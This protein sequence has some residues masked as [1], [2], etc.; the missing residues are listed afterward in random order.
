MYFDWS[1]GNWGIA[2]FLSQCD[3]LEIPNWIRGACAKLKQLCDPP[4]PGKSP[5][6]DAAAGFAPEAAAK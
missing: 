1:K 4:S 3:E 2:E 6:N 5:A